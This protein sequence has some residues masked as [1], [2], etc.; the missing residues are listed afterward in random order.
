[1][2]RQFIH[3]HHRRQE[4]AWTDPGRCLGS[5]SREGK[6]SRVWEREFKI[7]WSTGH[8]RVYLQTRYNE[9]IDKQQHKEQLNDLLSSKCFIIEGYKFRF[10]DSIQKFAE[11]NQLKLEKTKAVFLK[12]SDLAN[13]KLAIVKRRFAR[14]PLTFK[15][16]LNADC[17]QVVEF[18]QINFEWED[19]L[20]PEK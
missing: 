19:I 2:K 14:A 16:E 13:D 6:P 1:M 3:E 8:P 9:A 7:D 10:T 11:I 12:I 15:R 18:A 5:E 20:Q 4:K 17:S